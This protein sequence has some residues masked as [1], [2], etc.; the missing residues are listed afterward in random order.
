MSMN[1]TQREYVVP[2]IA[3]AV[4]S[5]AIVAGAVVGLALAERDDAPLLLGVLGTIAVAPVFAAIFPLI[6][7]VNR[8]AKANEATAQDVA[9]LK[10]H[11]HGGLTE[12]IRQATSDGIAPLL[13]YMR[14]IES[15]LERIKQRLEDGDKRFDEQQERQL[16]NRRLI[17][18]LRVEVEGLRE[19][20][21]AT[22]MCEVPAG[23][24]S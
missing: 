21:E 20:L 23:E 13:D 3:G 17:E 5:V 2:A 10:H 15:T 18:G 7:G 8:T 19:Q 6:K 12:R 11:M 14:G 22:P 16:E 4:A 1:G 24:G 9:D